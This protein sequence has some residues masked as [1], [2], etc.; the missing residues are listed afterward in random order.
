MRGTRIRRLI[1]ALGTIVVITLTATVPV[2]ASGARRGASPGAPGIGDPY[3]PEAGNG[4]Y[5]VGHYA[6]DIGYHPK[7]NRLDGVTTITA[8]ATQALSSFDLDLKGLRI[9]SILVDGVDATWTREQVHELVVTPAA[10]I[11]QS[12]T[13]TVVVTYSGLPWSFEIPGTS[14]LTG[15]VRTDDGAV[16]WGEPDVAA[17]WF[18]SNDHPRDKATYEIAITV[19]DGIKAISNGRFLGRSAG[20]PGRSTWSWEVTSPMASYL[21]LAAI[22]RFQIR[23]YHTAAGIPV[24][25]AWD[26]RVSDE[27]VESLRTEERAIRFLSDNFGPYPF[28]A[29]GGVVDHEQLGAALE[30]QTRPIYSEGFFAGRRNAY[31]VI[32]ELAHQWYGDSVSVDAWRH[33]WLNEG[34]ATYAEWLWNQERGFAAPGAIARYYCGIPRGSRFWEIEPGDPHVRNL[35]SDPVYVRG[36]MALQALRQAVGAD[37]FFEILQTWA[38]DRADMTGT[39]DQF[40]TVAETVSG[41]QLDDLFDE[42]LLTPHRPPSCA[43]L[44]PTSARGIPAILLPRSV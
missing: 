37:A 25:D 39:T 43:T 10:P 2:A 31:V 42:W 24:L 32:H 4:G 14:V 21:A 6:L 41:M 33:V 13:F 27:A 18:P 36:A 11:A 16:I 35:F 40:V 17:A 28:D 15:V 9:S 30:N 38:A 1:I 7:T 26:P 20:G 29:L 44:R 23:R 3:F 19:P 8:T 22:G 12:A 5:D 34:F